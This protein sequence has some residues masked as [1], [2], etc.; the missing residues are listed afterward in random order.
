MTENLWPIGGRVGAT[1]GEAYNSMT[2]PLGVVRVR[3]HRGA[4]R[5]RVA[6]T[7][8]LGPIGRPA[9]PRA[10]EADGS[11][12]AACSP[13]WRSPATSYCS[14]SSPTSF[15]ERDQAIHAASAAS[16]TRPERA[17]CSTS[18]NEQARN[19]FSPAQ[20]ARPRR[21]PCGSAAAARPAAA[22]PRSRRPCPASRD[23]RRTGSR[24]EA[25]QE[26]RRIHP[27]RSV[28]LGV[29][30]ALAVE[31]AFLDLVADL[32]PDALP[33]V[34]GTVMTVLPHRPHRAVEGRPQHDPGVGEVLL[35]PADL[36]HPVVGLG[37]S[38]PRGS[39]SARAA[40]ARRCRSPGAPTLRAACRASITWPNAS[41]WNCVVGAVACTHG[42]GTVVAGEA[43]PRSATPRP[44][45]ARPQAVHDLH[46]GR[47]AR[48]RAQQP[49]CASSPPRRGS[50]DRA[51]RAG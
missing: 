39:P 2:D 13:A 43:T 10:R 14:L 7:A 44:G 47:V 26:Q 12:P 49:A 25:A 42:F 17:Y 18:Q 19:G 22:R 36:P 11:A 45:A 37:S 33:P 1:V 4:R 46:V 21:S 30:V 41:P 9:H 51:V 48:D 6:A 5:D 27:I 38:A 15:G 3:T 35:R 20:A 31:P 29:G 40:A 24:P 23:R 16:S 32:V 28:V 34:G 8:Q 50:R